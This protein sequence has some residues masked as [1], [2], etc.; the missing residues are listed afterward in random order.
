MIDIKNLKFSY[1]SFP[2]LNGI[3]TRLESGK[4]YGLLG[5]NGVGKT[6][7]LTLLAGMKKPQE[8]QIILESGH[9]PYERRPSDLSQIFY[10]ADTVAPFKSSALDY[11]KDWG[12]FWPN[13]SME[14]FVAIMA[15]LENDAQKKMDQMSL[16][17][18]KK[19]HIAFALASG[20]RYIFM[21]EPTNGLDIPS[22][23]QF[24]KVLFKY[25][26][27]DTTIVISTHQVKDL[28]NI[29]D[30]IIILDYKEVLLNA[31]LQ[32][33]SEKLYF[34]YSNTIK[35]DSLYSEMIPGGAI[36]VRLNSEGVE[37]K[38]NIEA[39]FNT[40]HNNKELIRGIF[41]K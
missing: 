15:E 37:S 2:V 18:L 6:T 8:G 20:C 28:E 14:N 32:E 38:V 25:I 1:G 34:D 31:S 7:L 35:E 27:E 29:I 19:T 40:V 3:S 5:E 16:G 24:R 22:K 13:F 21:D 39:L 41:R 36:Q 12:A 9:A 30:P 17:Q 4:I 26:G 33:I 11:A 23:S 10:L